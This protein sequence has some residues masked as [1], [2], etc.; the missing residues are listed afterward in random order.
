MSSLRRAGVAWVLLLLVLS[1]CRGST[2]SPA[3]PPDLQAQLL[4]ARDLPTAWA[5]DMSAPLGQDNEPACLYQAQ[6]DLQSGISAQAR[7]IGGTYLPTFTE[8]LSYFGAASA[9]SAALIRASN[10]LTTCG[11]VAFNSG[12]TSYVG[13]VSWALA[14][15]MGSDA[16]AWR[17]SLWGSDLSVIGAYLILARHDAIV[18]LAIVADSRQPVRPA[19]LALPVTAY[20]KIT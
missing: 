6:T 11:R 15:G 14:A 13:D 10:A 2:S 5:T 20:F 18:L 4:S 7:F 9:A 19:L 16:R 12:M 3:A 17:L 8:S 1:A